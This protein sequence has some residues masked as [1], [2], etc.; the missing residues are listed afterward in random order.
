MPLNFETGAAAIKQQYGLSDEQMALLQQDVEKLSPQR[1][2]SLSEAYVLSWKTINEGVNN[3]ACQPPTLTAPN[4]SEILRLSGWT[5]DA[6]YPSPGATIAAV[7]TEL[8][9][10]QRQQN[11]EQFMEEAESIAATMKDQAAD[12]RK[13]A[14]TQWT[15]ALASGIVSG[16]FGLASAIGASISLY[17]V[18]SLSNQIATVEKATKPDKVVD[19]VEKLDVSNSTEAISKL[20]DNL[21]T[22]INN[23]TLQNTILQ[24]LNAA[25][26]AVASILTAKGQHDAT[27]IDADIKEKDAHIEKRRAFME[28]MRAFDQALTDLINK[29]LSASE[30][31][32]QAM[33]Q[34]RGR[35]LG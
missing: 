28:N 27:Y 20:Q 23:M 11:R 7:L 6:A 31:I 22:H 14:D 24:G 5:G 10:E 26:Q 19:I 35:I 25:G 1:Q 8:A 30:S 16:V 21:S 2:A 17:K 4:L 33:N 32:Q 13:K 9:A 3:Y 34:A 18:A 15:M 12:L 29:V